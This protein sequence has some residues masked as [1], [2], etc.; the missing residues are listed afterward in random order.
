MA[1]TYR[2]DTDHHSHDNVCVVD[3]ETIAHGYEGDGFPPWPLHVP[4]CASVLIAER[5]SQGGIAFE[6]KTIMFDGREAEA[7]DEL[8]AAIKDRVV[9]TYNGRGFDLPVLALTAM[10]NRRF[11][12]RALTEQWLSNRYGNS[13]CDLA[14]Q[15]S[16]YGAARGASLEALCHAL[17]ISAK[18]SVNGNDVSALY[19]AG[20]LEAIQ[21]YCEEDVTATYMLFLYWIALR[22]GDPSLLSGGWS[23]L[24]RFIE[25][26][27]YLHLHAFAN[28]DDVA[29]AHD[30]R[31]KEMG[32]RLVRHL[33]QKARVA[34]SRFTTDDD[35]DF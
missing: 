10:R 12:S 9:V 5:D 13:H 26:G 15:F 35:I 22:A 20:N 16:R 34:K 1:N 28:I 17:N 32:D 25:R 11:S 8:E 31:R 19:A 3:I 23:Q 33:L 6:L 27:G 4:V 18:S 2:R 24:A 14:E 30:A 21:R 29:W 7:L